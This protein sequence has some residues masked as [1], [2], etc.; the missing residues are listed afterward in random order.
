MK[1]FRLFLFLF[2][3][4]GLADN[5]SEL[6]AQDIDVEE[7]ITRHSIDC[8][9][10]ARSATSMIPGYYQAEDT[11]TLQA[12]LRYWEESC[13]ITEPMM[14]FTIL[15][16]IETNTFNEDWLPD[17]LPAML[18]DYREATES[19]TDTHDYFHFGEWEYHA[20]DEGYRRF[21][22]SMAERLQAYEDLSPVESFFANFYGH[23]FE[24]AMSWLGDGALEGTR[25]DS[26]Y[27]EHIEESREIRPAGYTHG[28]FYFGFWSPSGNLDALGV[29]PQV[30]MSMDMIRGRALY[31]F[32][33]RLGFGDTSRPYTT[34][35]GGNHVSTNNFLQLTAGLQLGVDLLN[36]ASHSLFMTG[37]LAYDAIDPTSAAEREAGLTGNLQTLNLNTGLT[38]HRRF[39]RGNLFSIMVNYHIV[40]YDNPGGTDLSGNVLTFG[41]AYGIMTRTYDSEPR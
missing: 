32:Q 41:I 37:G 16:Q 21:T 5:A 12:I 18:M 17:H 33:L 15:W 24:R 7:M 29:H 4:T 1:P 23:D 28:G 36:S 14:R 31:G 22:S 19:E 39:E 27:A 8:E 20:I 40:N 10:I 13:G 38:L 2:L 3:F 11:D 9:D 25:V 26:L 6:L 30:G 34:E 35:I